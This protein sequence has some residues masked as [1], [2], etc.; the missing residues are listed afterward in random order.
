MRGRHSNMQRCWRGAFLFLWF[1]AGA[2]LLAGADIDQSRFEVGVL[3]GGVRARVLG[4]HPVGAGGRV[5]IHTF[6]FIE[7]EA[8]VSRYPVGGGVALF[9]VTQ[10]LFGVRA[11]RR[12]GGIGVYSKLRPGFMR[13][14]S[15]LYVPRLGTRAALD[16]GGIVEF[17]SRRHV[18]AR[19]DFGDTVVW[20]GSDIVIP[21]ISGIGGNVVP[22]T[23]H[24]FQWNLGLSV[25]F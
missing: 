25:W 22:R 3:L 4:E 19:V 10:G 21:P 23:R 18:A 15:N 9:P 1:C 24:Q 11:G 8:E 17:Y 2:S 13:F 6:R 5:T 20:Y 16:A 12:I 14:D 7:A